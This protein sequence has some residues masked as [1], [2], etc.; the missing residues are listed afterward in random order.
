MRPPAGPFPPR[1]PAGGK[2]RRAAFSGAFQPALLFGV[3]FLFYHK[4]KRAAVMRRG[5]IRSLWNLPCAFTA[6]S[7]LLQFWRAPGNIIAF[8]IDEWPEYCI[9]P[10]DRAFHIRLHKILKARRDKCSAA[11]GAFAPCGAAAGQP[12]LPAAGRGCKQTGG[13]VK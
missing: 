8:L 9:C 1:L 12:P 2:R 4:M 7:R 5:D 6:I 3:V 11:A 13:I 10:D